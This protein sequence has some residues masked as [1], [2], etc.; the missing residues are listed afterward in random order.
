MG[1]GPLHSN[2]VLSLRTGLAAPVLLLAALAACG[3]GDEP[4]PTAIDTTPT[5]INGSTVVPVTPVDKPEGVPA[6]ARDIEQSATLGR[7]VR[8]ANEPP[9]A[10]ETR[11]LE[12]TSCE[13][14]LFVL[15]TSE[16]TIYAPHDCDSL[17]SP[18]SEVDYVGHDVA[19]VLEVTETRFRILIETAAGAQAEFT[20]PGIWVD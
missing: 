15:R 2:D 19:I 3:G 5:L 18:E 17:W 4:R 13:D 10:I 9:E 12:D 14:G 6:S 16:E 7:F 11:R 8:R 1:A 20:V